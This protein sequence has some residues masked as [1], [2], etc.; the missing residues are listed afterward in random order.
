MSGKTVAFYSMEMENPEIYERLLSKTA[1]IPMNTLID[2]RFQDKKRPQ[3]IRNEELSRIEK[4]TTNL[5][6]L[7][8]KIND[9]PNISVN[10][11]RTQCRMIKNLGLIV[12]D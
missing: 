10:E 12:I 5:K 9:K 8:L 6:T 2:R 1:Q 3:S 11:I 7:P 4:V